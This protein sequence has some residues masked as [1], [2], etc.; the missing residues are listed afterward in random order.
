[1][2][3]THYLQE[4]KTIKAF[5]FDVDGVLT[6]G[7]LFVQERGEM[8]RTM[9]IR[10]GYAIQLAV[11]KGY[12]VCIIS[13]GKSEGVISRLKRLGVEDV[14]MG[15]DDKT[16]KLEEYLISNN[17]KA[18]DILYM[19]DDMPDFD[20]MSIVGFPCCPADAVQEIVTLCKYISPLKGGRGCVR[21]VIEKVL[22]LNNCWE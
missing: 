10:D 6:D 9:Y 16:E 5:V 3:D 12:K 13:G 8:L 11:K 15:V 18:K 17:L 21:D 19:G 14:F 1:M 22:K 4:M 7:S 20:V 2:A